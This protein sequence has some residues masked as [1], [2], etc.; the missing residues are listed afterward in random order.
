MSDIRKF[1]FHTRVKEGAPQHETVMTVDC[2]GMTQELWEAFAFGAL[3][4]KI[5]QPMRKKGVIPA[6]LSIVMKDH[7][8]GV[9]QSAAPPTKEEAKE[10]W[11]A[12]YAKASPEERTAMLKELMG[13]DIG[14]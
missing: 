2:T 9:R 3:V 14:A 10:I 4:V 5:Q 7:A 13:S 8:P 11:K 1:K 12:E 6:T